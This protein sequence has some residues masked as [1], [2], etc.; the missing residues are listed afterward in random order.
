MFTVMS[1]AERIC[2]ITGFHRSGTTVLTEAV[3]CAVPAP[4]LTVGDLAQYTPAL[5]ELLDS[6]QS[7]SVPLD[8]G[9]DGRPVSST[10]PEEYCVYLASRGRRK[11]RYG[12][13]AKAD[14]QAL[15]DTVA[16][17]G[18]SRAAVMKNPWDT[19]NEAR[20]LKDF[21][22]AS[23]VI[24]RRALPEIEASQRAAFARERDSDEYMGTLLPGELVQRIWQFVHRGQLL[25]RLINSISVWR[26]RLRTLRLASQVHRLP[27]DRTALLSYDEFKTD[28]RA[29]AQWASHLLD[30]DVLAEEFA[31][32]CAPFGAEH[33][34]ANVSRVGAAIDRYWARS[35]ERTR[36][37]HV[38]ARS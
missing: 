4:M 32:R 38:R 35:W 11:L 2:F 1:T 6:L 3:A 22:H 10:M 30:P 26:L 5:A 23:V 16:A 14:L 12:S 7:R 9:V 15:A 31:A 21:P 13:R 17:R 18:D 37:Q 24:V 8:R 28:P 34:P 33:R 20:L 25:P 36:A 27:P 19:A 29:A